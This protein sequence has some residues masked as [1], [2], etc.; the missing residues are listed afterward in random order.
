M[1][2]RR[3]SIQSYSETMMRMR[4]RV[5]VQHILTALSHLSW[6]LCMWEGALLRSHKRQATTG[7]SFHHHQQEQHRSCSMEKRE[8]HHSYC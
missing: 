2:R 8:L 3:L 6:S 5:P 7:N 4:W 1:K